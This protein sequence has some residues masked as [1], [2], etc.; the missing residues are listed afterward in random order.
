[1]T[2]QSDLKY[3]NLNPG[4]TWTF[5]KTSGVSASGAFLRKYEYAEKA[6][7]YKP[8]VVVKL[9]FIDVHEGDSKS[10]G[11]SNRKRGVRDGKY[12]WG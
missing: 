12:E 5:G 11:F 1:M 4:I 2:R 3:V 6:L 10:P 9:F 7:I 8:A